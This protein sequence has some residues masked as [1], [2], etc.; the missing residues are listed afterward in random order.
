MVR[1]QAA[2]GERGCQEVVDHLLGPI[3]RRREL[4]AP[5]PVDVVVNIARWAAQLPPEALKAAAHRVLEERHSAVTEESIVAAIRAVHTDV[6]LKVPLDRPAAPA[7]AADGLMS[8][9]VEM[10]AMVIALRLRPK[11]ISTSRPASWPWRP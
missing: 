6:G 10:R 5:D 4:M 11:K 1:R 9:T 2:V 7:A 3:L 8:I